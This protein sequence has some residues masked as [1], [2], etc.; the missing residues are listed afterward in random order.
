M[1]SGYESVTEDELKYVVETTK[2]TEVDLGCRF[3]MM[4]FFEKG[5]DRLIKFNPADPIMAKVAESRGKGGT[6]HFF[7]A[8]YSCLH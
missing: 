4:I 1:F 8:G 7:G 3:S 6:T 2:C 5:K